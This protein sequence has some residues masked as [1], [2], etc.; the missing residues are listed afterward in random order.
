MTPRRGGR[1]NLE[2]NIGRPIVAAETETNVPRY[3]APPKKRVIA[4]L[5]YSNGPARGG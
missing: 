2:W 3:G 5:V 4:S 1:R